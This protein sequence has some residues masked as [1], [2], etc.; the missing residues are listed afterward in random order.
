MNLKWRLVDSNAGEDIPEPKLFEEDYRDGIVRFRRNINKYSED[1]GDGTTSEY[2]RYEEAILTTEEYKM[3]QIYLET[4]ET[5][6]NIELALAEL[7][8]LAVQ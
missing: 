3:Y 5:Q 7:A 1:N 2:Y 4:K 6:T 8:E